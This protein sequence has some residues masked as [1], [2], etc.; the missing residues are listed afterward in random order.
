MTCW[1]GH[2]NAPAILAFADGGFFLGDAFGSHSKPV[3][4]ECVFNTAMTGYQEMLTDPSYAGQMLC[5]TAPHIGN[6]GVNDADMESA[7]P[8]LSACIASHISSRVQHWRSTQNLSDFCTHYQIPGITGVDTR[9]ITQ[10]VR[11]RGAQGACLMMAAPTQENISDA[12]ARAKA[13]KGW[14]GVD[15]VSRVTT[16]RAQQVTSTSH[17]LQGHQHAEP[18]S[19]GQVV[20]LDYGVKTQICRYWVDLGYTV[21]VLPAQSTAA[22]VLSYQPDACIL[23]NGPGDPAACLYQI[24]VIKQ[25]CEA[26]LPL[27]GICLGSQLLAL[28]LG[29]QTIK[30]PFG[31]HGANHPVQHC[32]SNRVLITSQN[33]GFAIDE[34]TL[35]PTLVVTHRSLFDQTVQGFR[36]RDYPWVAVQGHPEASPGPQDWRHFFYTFHEMLSHAKTV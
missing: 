24:E 7:S 4:A 23:S 34:S 29:A 6:V 5:F 11:D 12:I 28:A 25:L 3:V 36:H 16:E 26:Q 14:V 19:A 9:A 31:H 15:W 30:L 21:T 22:D 35:P 32:R 17:A 13:Y 10:H 1:L 18:G 27:F 2:K 20:V 33:H 8:Q